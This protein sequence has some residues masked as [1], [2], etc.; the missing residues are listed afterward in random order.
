MWFTI[1]DANGKSK[2]VYTS[3]IYTTHIENMIRSELYL[4]LRT[5][6]EI[7]PEGSD[8]TSAIINPETRRSLYYLKDWFTDYKE[9]PSNVLGYAYY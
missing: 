1:P 5:H 7:L 3:E 8:L 4:P 6:Y 9:L 2:K